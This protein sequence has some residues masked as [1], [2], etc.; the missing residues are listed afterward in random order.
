M[1]EGL[2]YIQAGEVLIPALTME[3]ETEDI[4]KY[5][6]MREKYIREHR[7]GLYQA[8][9]LS[10]KLTKHLARVNRETQERVDEIVRQLT[11]TDPGPDK[12]DDQMGWV[13]Y[14]NSLIS[15]AEE[16]ALTELVYS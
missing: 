7:R 14:Q 12:A 3:E 9:L 1:I 10:G 8:L 4:G 6:S 11:E 16:I 2:T 15:Q 13:R 5:G